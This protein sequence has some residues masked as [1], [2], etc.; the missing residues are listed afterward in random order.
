MP[1][2]SSPASAPPFTHAVLFRYGQEKLLQTFLDNPRIAAILETTA[3]TAA[4]GVATLCFTTAVPNELEAIFRRGSEWDEG[5]ELVAALDLQ[6]GSDEADA[7]EFLDLT[8][9]LATSSA[10][11]AVQAAAGRFNSVR[12]HLGEE[13]NE[14]LNP[15]FMIHVRFETK[16]QLEA[17]VQCPPVAAILE[18]DERA[19]LKAAWAMALA[20]AP[21]ENSNS[22]PQKGSPSVF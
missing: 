3:G 12:K 19:P 18:G 11:G 8:Q 22:S 15:D 10:F 2:A 21:A 16:E 13:S 5:F 20:V 6:P 7:S 4:E 9:Q 14:T 17:F 1:L